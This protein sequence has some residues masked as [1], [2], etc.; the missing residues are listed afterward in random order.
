VAERISFFTLI[1]EKGA[2]Y[3]SQA[4]Y[5]ATPAAVLIA[6]FFFGGGSD[7]WLWASLA[8]LMVAL[9]LNNSGAIRPAAIQP[10][11]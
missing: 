11:S 1:R 4:I 2:A 6:M 5:L 3:T 10:S 7:A 9:Y 8:L